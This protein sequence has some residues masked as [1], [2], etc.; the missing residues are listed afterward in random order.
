MG[1]TTKKPRASDRRP[2]LDPN[3]ARK[4]TLRRDDLAA[5]VLFTIYLYKLD[6]KHKILTCQRMVSVN[7]NLAVLHVSDYDRDLPPIFQAQ[8]QLLSYLRLNV[9]RNLA[10]LDL[11]Y[12]VFAAR[13]IPFSRWDF[14]G[15]FIA[16]L[17]ADDSLFETFNDL[18]FAYGKSEGFLPL[19][20]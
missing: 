13:T 20:R 5:A 15:L 9:L 7:S 18:P 19:A 8:L 16:R 3:R 4:V 2:G 12:E 1:D 14:G 10:L 11:H 6:L 17:H